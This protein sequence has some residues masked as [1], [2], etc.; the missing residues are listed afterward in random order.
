LKIFDSYGEGGTRKRV[1]GKNGKRNVF[2]CLLLS[3]K[4]IVRGQGEEDEEEKLQEG[5][6]KTLL[7][8]GRQCVR[9]VIWKGKGSFKKGG[10]GKKHANAKRRDPLSHVL[11]RYSFKENAKTGAK[12]E[13]RRGIGRRKKNRGEKMLPLKPKWTGAIR[14]KW[15]PSSKEGEEGGGVLAG[16]LLGTIKTAFRQVSGPRPSVQV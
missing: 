16:G 8:W 11:E 4:S 12:K 13:E 7:K 6:R 10:H 9:S 1:E 15:V 2:V 14:A 3:E 5:G